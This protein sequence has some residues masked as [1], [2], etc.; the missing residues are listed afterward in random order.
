MKRRNWPI[1]I[2]LIAGAIT[3]IVTFLRGMAMVE[4]LLWLLITLV[5]FYGLGCLLV[6]VMN[7]FDEENERKLQ[8]EK[9]KAAEEEKQAQEQKEE[10]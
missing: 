2:M 10:N 7:S 3:S 4:K 6:N 8:E 1:V 9:K 5:L